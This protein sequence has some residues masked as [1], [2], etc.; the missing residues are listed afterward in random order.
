MHSDGELFLEAGLVALKQGNYQTAIAKLTPVASSKENTT[1]TLQARVGL[2]MAYAR[3]GQIRKATALCQLLTESQ[4]TQVKEW[5]ELALTHLTKRKKSSNNSP[6]PATGFVAFNSQTATASTHK[7][8][9]TAAETTSDDNSSGVKSGSLG[10]PMIPSVGYRNTIIAEVPVNTGSFFGS[11]SQTQTPSSS[12]YWR[13]AKRAKVWQPLRKPN[14]IPLRLLAVGTF[15]AVFWVLRE[16]LNSLTGFIN[17]ALVKLPYLKPLQF[18]YRNPTPFLLIVLFIIIGLSPWLLDWLLADFYGQRELSKDVL[19]SHSRETARVLQRYCQQR[20][21]QSPKLRILPIAAPM[22][23]TYGNLARNA[24]IVVSQG[25]LE[26]LADDEIATIYATQLGHIAHGDFVV[27]S[28]VLL[29]TLPIHRLYQQI[30]TWG[31]KKSEGIWYKPITILASVIYAL[32]CLLTGISLWLSRLRLYY[33]D[34]LAAEITGN[35]NALT[36]ALLKIAIGIAVDI[37][38]SEQTSW[39]LSSLNLFIPVGYQQSLALGSLAGQLPFESILM[40]DTVYP[41]SRWLA[42]NNSHPLIGDR[43]QRLSQIARHWHIDPELHLTSP[44]LSVAEAQSSNQVKRHSFLL[45]IAPFLGVPLGVVFAGLIWLTWQTAFTFRLIN[46]KWIYENWNFVTGCLL[47]GFSIGTLF[48]M[49]SFFPDIKTATVQNDQSLPNLLAHPSAIPVD[50]ITVRLTGKLLGRRGTGNCLGQD[51]ILQ[52]STG[53]VKLHHI[54]LGQSV[55]PQDLIGRQIIV[56]GWF[57]RGATPWI[58][59]QTVQ[60]QSGKTIHSPHPIWSIVV[61]V[62]AQAWGAYIFLTG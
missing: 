47:I 32:W 17:F 7:L 3:T 1:A 13:Q 53:L 25:L 12:I 22:A 8:H 36:R 6:N 28:L 57:R 55:N 44:D 61:A 56:T 40:W 15:V 20:R 27:M 5:A 2:V 48:R 16:I 18:L 62:A 24:R 35:P 45:Q 4:N 51:L 21:W 14:L 46:L 50:S 30:S 9:N 54:P 58:D 10:N 23:L 19:H 38:K 26:Q 49:N 11:T 29:L 39:H 41:Y 34:R 33:S 60:S 43:I 37:Q 59:I 31:N 42:I 52:S